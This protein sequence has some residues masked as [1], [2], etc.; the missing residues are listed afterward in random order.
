MFQ[1]FAY[2]TAFNQPLNNWDVSNVA[3]MINMFYGATSFNQ[4]LTA[5]VDK[6]GR[7]TT[8]MFKGATAMQASNKPSWVR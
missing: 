7:R 2:A 1:V 5:W 3:N 8:D 4:D 6:S